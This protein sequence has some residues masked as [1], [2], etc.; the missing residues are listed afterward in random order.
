MAMNDEETAALTAGGHTVGKTHGNGDAALLGPSP[1]GADIAEQGLGW[2]NAHGS[3]V[4]AHA[5]TSGIEGAWKPNPTTWDMG[6]LQTLFGHDWE[7]TKSPAGAHQ[8]API[9]IA[10]EDMPVD[11][12]DPSIRCQPVMTDAAMA[13]KFDPEYRKIAER[14]VRLGLVL[15]EIGEQA[16]Q[17][18]L[19]RAGLALRTGR[20]DGVERGQ[21]AG[22]APAPEIAAFEE[23]AGIGGAACRQHDVVG[24]DRAGGD[25]GAD[26]A[27]ASGDEQNLL[28]NLPPARGE[29]ISY[30]LQP[31]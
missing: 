29:R 31:H 22:R 17:R 2:K 26:A 12:E 23:L 3:G 19:D 16:A 8:W 21:D 25:R 6:Y 27:A 14:R 15:A 1:E 13:L 30:N 11:V 10:P 20:D 4:G 28:Q 7:L 9:N 18:R 24:D 5:T